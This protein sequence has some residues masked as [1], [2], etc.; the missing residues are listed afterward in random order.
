[1]SWITDPAGAGEEM[2]VGFLEGLGRSIMHGISEFADTLGLGGALIGCF[3]Y[4][5]GIR[6][7]GKYIRWSLTLWLIVRIW[8]S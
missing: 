2:A 8:L 3:L 4:M 1:M 7:G 6:E 5:C